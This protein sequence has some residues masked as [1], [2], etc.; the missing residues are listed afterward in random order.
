MWDREIKF[1][2]RAKRQKPPQAGMLSQT[3]LAFLRFG[4]SPEF[5]A[6]GRMNELSKGKDVQDFPTLRRWIVMQLL[7]GL[8]AQEMSQG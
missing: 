5:G 1:G 4:H 3:K 2:H 8:D 6:Q 7:L